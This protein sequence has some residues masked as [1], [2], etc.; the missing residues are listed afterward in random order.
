MKKI[1]TGLL[2]LLLVTTAANAA[3]WSTYPTLGTPATTSD[4]LMTGDVSTGAIN[5]RLLFNGVSTDCLSASTP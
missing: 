4:Y 5:A 2:G 3:Q 1:L